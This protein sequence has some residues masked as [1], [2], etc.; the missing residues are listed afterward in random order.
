MSQCE[1][2]RR[3]DARLTAAAPSTTNATP[4]TSSGAMCTPVSASAAT[5]SSCAA[6]ACESTGAAASTGAGAPDRG[7]PLLDS[8]DEHDSVH[9]GGGGEHDSV[10]GGGGG[11]HDSVHEGEGD[12]TLSVQLVWAGLPCPTPWLR[13]HS[14]P[15]LLSEP[16][17]S[18]PGGFLLS[19][20]PT[21]PAHGL[22]PAFPSP[23][24]F[25]EAEPSRV[26]SYGP[27]TFA[28]LPL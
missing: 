8:S 17:G 19:A 14:Y 3:T 10:H 26:E 28:P 18:W 1:A 27:C 6:G 24:P 22:P 25:C 20:L 13:S 21:H 16:P 9:A 5:E 23:F 15:A 11:E 2:R 12:G 4:I 7:P